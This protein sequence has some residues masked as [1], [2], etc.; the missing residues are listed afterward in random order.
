M[1][2]VHALGIVHDYKEINKTQA[3]CLVCGEYSECRIL[4]YVKA[5]H[6]FTFKV[7]ILNEQYIFDWEECRHRA[8]L[9]DPQDVA[10]YRLEQMDTGILSVPYYSNMKLM[11][12]MM[13]KKV[14]AWKIIVVILLGVAFGLIVV[15]LQHRFHIP[16]VPLL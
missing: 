14:P 11:K 10:R 5:N 16:Y 4:R 13:P 1:I 7:K 15:Y 12:G 3:K 8:I 9:Y 6:I 2:G